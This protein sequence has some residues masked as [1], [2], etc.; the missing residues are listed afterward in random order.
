MV[1]WWLSVACSRDPWRGAGPAP[2]GPADETWTL[3]LHGHDVGVE[4]VW[5]EGDRQVRRRSLT[6]IA[7]GAP[8]THRLELRLEGT[9]PVRS[10][11]VWAGETVASD[12][13][14]WWSLAAL[15]EVEG[16]LPLLGS[17]GRI[18]PGELRRTDDELELLGP[19]GRTRVRLGDDGRPAVAR[20]AGV[21]ATRAA[22]D[23]P[24]PEPV[25]IAAL[26]TLPAPSFPSARRAL[27]GR[28]RVGGEEVRVDVPTF[29]ELPPE[30]ERARILAREVDADLRDVASPFG[31]TAGSGD[32]TEHALLF[33]RR[34]T[35]AGFEA[36]T[37]AGYLLTVD[38]PALVP[39]AWAEVRLAGRWV[40]ADPALGQL[41]A[42]A[43]HLPLG[44]WTDEIAA[45]D[46][47]LVE[48]LDVR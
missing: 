22:G 33:V 28:Y 35:D 21:T 37:V 20:W 1:W 11:A 47:V 5:T 46:G 40:G 19:H 41:P 7:D 27:V 10:F 31:G 26:L 6:T 3:S 45:M 44:A 30:A 13:P 24:D 14:A 25:D 17:D 39:H 48:V 43:G 29:A 36:R 8:A 38:P 18:G 15:P 4:R 23:R 9:S 42:D 16:P 12:G 34:A 32:C 2:S